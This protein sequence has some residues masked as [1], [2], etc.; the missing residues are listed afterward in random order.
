MCVCVYGV[1]VVV[2]C[3]HMS[4][5]ISGTSDGQKREL[6]SMGSRLQI[7]VSQ[8]VGVGN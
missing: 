1:F 6:D 3:L 2:V 4:L 5:C 8:H 7:A